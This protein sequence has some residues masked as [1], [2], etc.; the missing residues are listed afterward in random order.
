MS[1][2]VRT[3]AVFNDFL[4]DGPTG[5]DN[6]R[7][8]RE[9]LA[10]LVRH[11]AGSPF[12]VRELG[13]DQP[14]ERRLDTAA[15]MR[16]LD[17]PADP[18]GWA[19]AWDA[20]PSGRFTELVADRLAGTHLVVG[21]GLPN[22]VVRSLDALAVPFLDFEVSPLRFARNLELDA[23]T[24]I[25]AL[26]ACPAWQVPLGRFG[27][28]AAD[29]VGWAAR[30]CPRSIPADAGAVGVIFGQ[31]DLDAALVHDG[32]IADFSR[33]AP[34]IR[35]WAEG[36]DHVLFRPHP[37]AAGTRALEQ[38]QRI[39]PRIRTTLMNSYQLLASQRLTRVL[40]LSSG[41]IDEAAFFRVAAMRLFMPKRRTSGLPYSIAA[42]LNLLRGDV[43][44]PALEGVSPPT[45]PIDEFDLRRQFR[46]AWGLT[47]KPVP[48]DFHAPPPLVPAVVPTAVPLK[49]KLRHRLR[50]FARQLTGFTRLGNAAGVSPMPAVAHGVGPQPAAAADA[51]DFSYG[52]GERQTAHEYA[53]IRRDHR[54]RYELAH[55]L[56]P[57]GIAVLDLF[58]GN[59]YGSFLLSESRDVLG[60]DG[61]QP[62][63]EVADRCFKRSGT[64]FMARRYPFA[65]SRQYDAIVSYESI[66]HIPDGPAFFAF[67]VRLLRPGGWILYSTPNEDLLPFDR[68]VHVHHHRHYR[69]GETLDFARSGGLTIESWYG[70]DVYATIAGGRPALLAEDRMGLQSG[71]PGQ[72]TVV[73]ARKPVA[74]AA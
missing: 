32:R 56:L 14:P 30:C 44:E 46:L 57:Q 73:V 58:C 49:P 15:C 45:V 22:V 8:N 10:A 50:G 53:L 54:V 25:P 40:A 59:G 16:A 7:T 71:T 4:R 38:L 42:N 27:A 68:R 52:S 9:W 55:Q 23:R 12:Q 2:R 18:T 63:I 11:L 19:A 72:F 67:L 61:S 64:R 62:A 35:Q 60:I 28:A 17:L 47:D 31:T 66:E 74:R 29:S 20:E 34:A 3:I 48:S 24:N 41:I 33:F 36:L 1:E 51:K 21:F 39:L 65:D 70:Q 26:T 6:C 69:H 5:I 37:Y 43:L 13:N